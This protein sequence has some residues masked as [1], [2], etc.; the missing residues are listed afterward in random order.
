MHNGTSLPSSASHPAALVLVLALLAL[1]AVA[2]DVPPADEQLAAAV[3]AAPEAWREAATVLGYDS[4][5]K[6]VTL[7]DGT[8]DLVCL[9]DNPE[10]SRFSVA[11]YHRDLEPFMARGRELSAEGVTGGE[12]SKIR[13]REVEEGKL[14]MPRGPRTLYV[15]HG[16]GFDAAAGEVTEA[17][18]R[19]VIYVPF[20]TEESTGLSSQPVSGGPWL[21]GA[22]TAGAHI[23]I[24]PP[25]PE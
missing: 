3:L 9:A 18:L 20:A 13:F 15:L 14:E 11:C 7:R 16:S 1:P 23:M 10:D 2:A 24:T 4:E 17:F 19:W 25:R 8:N 6:V 5:G 22:G 21:M 12:R